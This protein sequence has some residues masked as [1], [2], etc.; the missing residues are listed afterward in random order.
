MPTLVN[1]GPYMVP[2]T[3]HVFWENANND[4]NRLSSWRTRILDSYTAGDWVNI[5]NFDIGGITLL[6]PPN[7]SLVPFPV[8][9]Q[10]RRRASAPS[11]SYSP[12]IWARLDSNASNMPLIP[13]VV[14]RCNE[15]LGYVDS[16]VLE[17]ASFQTEHYWIV[18]VYGPTGG[19]GET[20][21]HTVTFIWDEP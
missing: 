10:W 7:G 11:D 14:V 3:Y 1:A 5:G 2:Q 17:Y 9:F 21:R 18:Q 16:F 13:P 8:E 19:K 6:S 12:C 15:P 20:H 4:P